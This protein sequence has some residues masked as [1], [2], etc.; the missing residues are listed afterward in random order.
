MQRRAIVV[1]VSHYSKGSLGSYASFSNNAN[2]IAD[3]LEPTF[4]VKRLPE[5]VDGDRVRVGKGGV[6]SDRLQDELCQLFTATDL[7]TVL[8]YFSGHGLRGKQ[9]FPKTY[10]A[11]MD[12]DAFDNGY[13]RAFEIDDLKKLLVNCPAREQIVWLDCCYGGDLA[14]FSEVCDRKDG[15]MRF[16][17]TASRSQDPA[18]QE[19]AG[20]MGVFTRALVDA[21]ARAGETERRI[22]CAAIEDAVREKLQKLQYPQMPQFYRTPNKMIEF[23]ERRVMSEDKQ[24]ELEQDLP[25]NSDVSI[26]Q[27]A[28]ENVRAGGNINVHI[29]QNANQRNKNMGKESPQGN[30]TS[31]D[32]REVMRQR[33]IDILKREIEIVKNQWE[34]AISDEQREQLWLRLEQKIVQLEE[35]E[36][37]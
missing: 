28:M 37:G 2:A 10:L 6:T 22:T 8:F 11:A 14:D 25:R 24:G 29:I 16:I 7:D 15:K 18:Y 31:T 3:I 36:R 32:L 20:E 4:K 21:L 26:V 34:S 5:A 27:K 1:G 17:I 9:L 35:T 30:N 33:K 12:S 13:R 23:W 19:I